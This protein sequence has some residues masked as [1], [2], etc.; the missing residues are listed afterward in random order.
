MREAG[1]E[2]KNQGCTEMSRLSGQRNA[3]TSSGLCDL[4]KTINLS[5]IM[6]SVAQFGLRNN[7]YNVYNVVNTMCSTWQVHNRRSFS[8]PEALPEVLLQGKS[9][10]IYNHAL[11][12]CLISFLY[13]LWKKIYEPIATEQR[14][15]RGLV[16]TVEGGWRGQ[17]LFPSSG[18]H[19][20]E[21]SR[22]SFEEAG[23]ICDGGLH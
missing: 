6:T 14:V 8:F 1:V 21:V 18:G 12:P 15:P 19:R 13:M 4:R 20:Q 23:K 16:M 5:G 17:S 9:L 3:I 10:P 2:R 7:C 11:S 22:M